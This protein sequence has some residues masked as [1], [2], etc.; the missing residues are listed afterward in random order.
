M[1]ADDGTNDE[2]KE[3]SVRKLILSFEHCCRLSNLLVIV[4][5][6]CSHCYPGW[7]R[8]THPSMNAHWFDGP[9]C[10]SYNAS[11]HCVPTQQLSFV[12]LLCSKRK[13]SICLSF[14]EGERMNVSVGD[15]DLAS[16]V[17]AVEMLTLFNSTHSRVGK[18][19][20]YFAI[21]DRMKAPQYRAD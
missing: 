20:L 14:R 1:R 21:T 2:M 16:A 9:R 4:G 7:K 15:T 3:C 6:A 11:S 12:I 13:R 5:S 10:H 19:K 18:R 17:T 8:L